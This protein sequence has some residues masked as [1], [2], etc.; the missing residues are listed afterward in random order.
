MQALNPGEAVLSEQPECAQALRP[1]VD[2]VM[3]G[4]ALRMR[5]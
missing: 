1:Q 4:F 2:H 5:R 3:M